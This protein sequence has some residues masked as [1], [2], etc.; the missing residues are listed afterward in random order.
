[1][2]LSNEHDQALIRSAVS[3]AAENLLSFIPSLGVRE[4]FTFGPGVAVPTRMRFSEIAEN[5]RPNSEAAGNTRSDVG[6]HISRDLISG[7]IDRWRSATM[8][9]R[10]GDEDFGDYTSPLDSP[11][12]QPAAP[13]APPP[14]PPPSMRPAPKLAPAA[15]AAVA[16]TTPPSPAAGVAARPSVLRKPLEGSSPYPLS[17]TPPASPGAP[18]FPSRFK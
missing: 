2:R 6:S 9:H 13:A 15:A 5:V 11:A 18:N 16:R 7:V 10:S 14:P 1:M 4:V 12:L 3:D 17:N 8:S